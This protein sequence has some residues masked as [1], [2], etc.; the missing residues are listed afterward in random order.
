MSNSRRQRGRASA[1]SDLMLAVRTAMTDPD[2]LH[3]LSYVSTLL[4]AVDPRGKVHPF[5]GP[6]PD[7]PSRDDLVAMFADVVAPETTALLA[8]IAAL[9]GDEVLQA[10]IWRELATREPVAPDWVGRL[11]QPLAHRAVRMNHILGDGDN[12]IVG[13]RLADGREATCIAYVDHNLGQLVKDAFVIPEPI[14]VIVAQYQRINDDPDTT[15]EELSLADARA[16]IDSAVEVGAMTFPPLESESWPAC[17]PLVEWITRSLPQGGTG[18]Q[19]PQWNPTQVDH[20]ADR[21]FNSEEGRGFD[22]ADHRGLLGSVLWFATDYGSGDPVRWSDVRVEMLLA[23]WLPR[24]VIAPVEYLAAAPELLWAFIRFAHHDSGVRADLTEQTL[25]AIDAW[26]PEY[27]RAIRT[28]R[29]GPDMFDGLPGSYEPNWF[30]EGELHTLAQEVGGPEKLDALDTRPLPDEA[31]DWS[32]IADDVA[33]RVD[34]VLALTDRCCDALLDVEYRTVCRR[35]LA[36]VASHAPKVF[37]RNA[38]A[39]TA[40]AGVVWIAGKANNLFDGKSGVRAMDIAKFFGVSSSPSG[41]GE[42]MRRAGF[43]GNGYDTDLGSP[44]YLVAKRRQWIIERRDE[45]RKRI[46]AAD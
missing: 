5:A 17:R 4:T 23:D 10:R 43:S 18:Y 24:K 22:D 19:R 6:T 16:W 34:E 15:W 41:R 28:P 37:R 11:E 35:I 30:E 42:V 20:L 14:D 7:Q 9:T 31:F 36:R 29:P 27:L 40:A 3:L 33:A 8:T 1:E 25:N 32:G 38:R 21:F 12:I 44:D 46:A 26:T 2:P 39:E 45:M 13:V